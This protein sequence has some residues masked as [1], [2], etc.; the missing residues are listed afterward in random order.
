MIGRQLVVIGLK[1]RKFSLDHGLNWPWEWA[2]S[3]I[4]HYWA[5]GLGVV[6]FFVIVIFSFETTMLG[7]LAGIPVGYLTR[8]V[9]R[10]DRSM[11][12]VGLSEE[13]GY[14]GD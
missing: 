10:I 9:W 14:S 6:L 8:N 3:R 7:F 12:K 5:G 11:P 4:F 13:E 2:D 1:Q